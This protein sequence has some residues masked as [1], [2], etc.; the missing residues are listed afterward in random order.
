MLAIGRILT[1]YVD[2][3]TLR[4]VCKDWHCAVSIT[5]PVFSDRLNALFFYDPLV[6]DEFS[7]KRLQLRKAL[8]K[9]TDYKD[10]HPMV[11]AF[12]LAYA[13]Q[14][15]PRLQL[16]PA[17]EYH[18]ADVL[19]L[20]RADDQYLLTYAD[21]CKFLVFKWG[22]NIWDVC[23]HLG[24]EQCPHKDYNT[25]AKLD[26]RAVSLKEAF[27]Q[28]RAPSQESEVLSVYGV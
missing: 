3:Y 11:R 27:D 6:Y 1:N 24:T 18:N 25:M 5:T 20:L 21:G 4:G 16:L 28:L 13:Y 10:L 23:A 15:D 17:A 12:F 22:G 19:P 8:Q 9:C 14:P 7:Y 2:P 26:A